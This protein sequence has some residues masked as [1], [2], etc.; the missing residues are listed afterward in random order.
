LVQRIQSEGGKV[1][2]FLLWGVFV[3]WCGFILYMV[4][5]VFQLFVWACQ[6]VLKLAGRGAERI[7]KMRMDKNE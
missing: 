7:K 5:L 6:Q 4:K 1:I 3:A 2:Q